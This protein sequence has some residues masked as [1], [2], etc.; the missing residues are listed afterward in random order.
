MRYHFGW[1]SPLDVQ[2]ALYLYSHE[3][4]GNET[5]NGMDFILVILTEMKFQTGMRFSY[6]QNLP[7]ATWISADSLDIAFNV[8]M[9]LKLVAGIDFISLG[10]LNFLIL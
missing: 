4:R 1:K 2:S 10:R 5:Q 6:E 8:Y 7:E 9:C 3:L